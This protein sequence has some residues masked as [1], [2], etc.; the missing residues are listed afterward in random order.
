MG[1]V[2]AKD[3]EV[4]AMQYN[5]LT[6]RMLAEGYTADNY[7]KDKVHIAGNYS[8]MENPLNNHY[9]GFE[10]NR[11]YRDG[12]VYKTGCGKYVYGK[13]T[14]SNMATHGVEWCHE[15]DNPVIRCP[16]DKAQCPDN[17]E[18]LHGMYGGGL[19]IQC[20]CVCHR[21]D[22]EYVYSNSIEKADCEREEERD[23]KYQE[24]SNAR[25]GRVCQNHMFYDERSREWNLVYDPKRCANVCY[26]KDGYCPILGKQLDKKRGNV[27]YDLKLIYRRNDLDG[28]LFEGQID[29]EIVKG[30]R[31]FKSPTS[32]DICKAY[33]ST[34]KDNL[35]RDVKLNQYHMELF[36]SEHHGRYFSVEVINIRAEQKESRDLLQDLEDIKNGIHISHASD[37]EQKQKEEKRKKREASKEVRVKSA[38][39]KVLEIGYENMEPFEQNR[40]CKLISFERLDELEEIRQQKINEK[41]EEP[42]QLSMFDMM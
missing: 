23:H 4:S 37:S 26:A 30:K 3:C 28:T 40:V 19:C 25:K 29:T 5:E 24:Y 21:T 32:M 1:C 7:P 14:L 20:W 34:C 16:Y 6:K 39:K 38:E 15:N 13:H 9:G 31:V 33:V 27:Y 12:F 42:V 35:E 11:V 10:Y 41:Q 18:R 36:M 22:E 2:R 8:H 17:D